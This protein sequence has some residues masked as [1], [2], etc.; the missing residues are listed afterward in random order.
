MQFDSWLGPTSNRRGDESNLTSVWISVFED[1]AFP[2]LEA[3]AEQGSPSVNLELEKGRIVRL[4]RSVQHDRDEEIGQA[5][6]VELR[7]KVKCWMAGARC[8]FITIDPQAM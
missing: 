4:D 8:L 5:A 7:D 6:S 3:L 2:D 1:H